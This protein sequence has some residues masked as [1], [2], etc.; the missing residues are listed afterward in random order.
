MYFVESLIEHAA[1]C[2]CVPIRKTLSNIM[3]PTVNYGSVTQ[4]RKI[5]I[6]PESHAP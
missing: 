6:K 5:L 2:I 4:V 1:V 3:G